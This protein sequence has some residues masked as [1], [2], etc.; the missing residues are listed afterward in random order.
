MITYEILHFILKLH[1]KLP[2]NVASLIFEDTALDVHFCNHQLWCRGYTLY[3]LLKLLLLFWGFLHAMSDYFIT[4]FDPKLSNLSDHVI[5][6]FLPLLI[7]NLDLNDRAS[8]SSDAIS[9][10]SYF[11]LKTE[12]VANLTLS[13]L[14]FETY[15]AVTNISETPKYFNHEL[16]KYLFICLLDL[17]SRL[18]PFFLK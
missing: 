11:S 15:P 2:G 7:L 14:L 5:L 13:I 9:Y 17:I 12:E 10:S 8:I 4:L 3:L 16:I 6:R 1:I 18:G